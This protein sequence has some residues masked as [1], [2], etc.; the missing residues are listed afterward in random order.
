MT[1]ELHKMHFLSE[2]SFLVK[3]PVSIANGK[4]SHLSCANKDLTLLEIVININCSGPNVVLNLIYD[5]SFR[6][7][8]TD[9]LHSS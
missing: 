7:D 5:H 1:L 8:F 4:T 3:R 2:M 6:N 9:V